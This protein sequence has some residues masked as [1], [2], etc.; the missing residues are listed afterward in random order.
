[1]PVKRGSTKF[2]DYDN[3]LEIIEFKTTKLSYKD[4][5]GVAQILQNL[6]RQ[7]KSEVAPVSAPTSNDLI[8][9]PWIFRKFFGWQNVIKKA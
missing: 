4:A 6:T 5:L 9:P 8:Q 1:M 2:L 3:E 7:S